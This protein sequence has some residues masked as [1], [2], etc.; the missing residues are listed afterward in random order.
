MWIDGR[1]DNNI[2]MGI[3]VLPFPYI[4][5][6]FE[7]RALDSVF[8]FFFFFCLF[9]YFR[10]CGKRAIDARTWSARPPIRKRLNT[11][12]VCV[13]VCE[14]NRCVL[15]D[16]QSSQSRVP[17]AEW[18]RKKPFLFYFFSLFFGSFYIYYKYHFL[19]LLLLFIR[20]RHLF[21][22]LVARYEKRQQQQRE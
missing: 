10:S 11:L 18:K 20:S 22:W 14:N 8:C 13:C 19:L 7:F 3:F 17:W 21:V 12:L 16:C 2:E 1:L 15:Y 5:P 6:D 9:V 4:I